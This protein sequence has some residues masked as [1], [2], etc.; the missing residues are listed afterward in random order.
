MKLSDFLIVKAIISLG[1]GIALVLIPV[2]MMSLLGATLDPTGIFVARGN[3]AGLIGIGLICWF[4][5]SA[6]RDALRG[7][8]LALFVSDTILLIATLL[9]QLSGIMNA[10]GWG[11]LAITLFLVLGLGYFRFLKLSPA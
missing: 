9:A 4:N 6:D 11:L 3:G 8:T 2:A 5:R 1:F 7:I 10:L